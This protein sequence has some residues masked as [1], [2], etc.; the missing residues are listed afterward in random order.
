MVENRLLLTVPISNINE[1]ISTNVYNIFIGSE[2]DRFYSTVDT[3]E[4]NHENIKNN[5]DEFQIADDELK[6]STLELIVK[7]IK[8]AIPEGTGISVHHENGELFYLINTS[9]KN[10]MLNIEKIISV[11]TQV[12]FSPTQVE[13][14]KKQ[15]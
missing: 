8:K 14:L 4:E 2:N 11:C 3:T 15:E 1:P 10:D 9:D 6:E 5:S 12:D 7:A 13:E